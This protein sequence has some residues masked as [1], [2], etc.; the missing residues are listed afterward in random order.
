[1]SDDILVRLDDGRAVI[2]TVTSD[3]FRVFEDE[4]LNAFGADLQYWQQFAARPGRINLG[5]LGGSKD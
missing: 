4:A 3:D 1:M 2:T 5:A